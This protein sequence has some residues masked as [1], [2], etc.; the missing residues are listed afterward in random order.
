[1]SGL[2]DGDGQQEAH[3][4]GSAGS[5]GASLSAGPGS[6]GWADPLLARVRAGR[7]YL[8]ARSLRER[9]MF[10]VVVLA[11]LVVVWNAA[12]MDGVRLRQV[13]L[14]QELA[15]VQE[16]LGAIEAQRR[17]ILHA[18][19]QN[20]NEALKA[21]EQSLGSQIQTLDARIG[22]HTVTLVPPPQMAEM[23]EEVLS[24][25]ASLRLVRLVNLGAEPVLESEEG[26][27]AAAG[28]YR[29]R[30]ELEL[31]GSYLATLGYLQAL[32]GLRW[33]FFW[34]GLDYTVE[35]HP[36]GRAV[37]RAYTLSSQEGFVGV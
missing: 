20:P 22:E 37:I 21:R 30:F 14:E 11:G 33:K 23:L 7:D 28:L 9:G 4:F 2:F 24:Q 17:S 5:D 35:D 1:M 26:E 18:H 25:D 15:R 31:Q 8:D 3:A 19:S 34:E 27:V 13:Q 36:D 16:Q 29:H 32:E 12:W 10:A 6:L